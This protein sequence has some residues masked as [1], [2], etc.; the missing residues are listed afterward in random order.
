MRKML[1]VVE[2]SAS[3]NNLFLVRFQDGFNKFLI[4]NQLTVLTLEMTPKTK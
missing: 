1:T 4:L 3:G 2:E